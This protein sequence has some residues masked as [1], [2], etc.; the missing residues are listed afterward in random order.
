M[1][2]VLFGAGGE[3]HPIDVYYQV[4]RLQYLIVGLCVL[5]LLQVVAKVHILFRVAGMMTRAERILKY[6][7]I[8]ASITDSQKERTER[9][10]QGAAS[11]VKQAVEQIPEKTIERIRELN[12]GDSNH[13]GSGSIPTVRG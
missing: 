4:I 11:E 12:A 2:G 9:S 5:V 13:G 7:E 8:H 1:S 10:V 3:V 6:S